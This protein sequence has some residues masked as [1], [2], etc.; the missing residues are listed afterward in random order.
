MLESVRAE[1]HNR[2]KGDAVRLEIESTATTEMVE[3]LRTNFELDSWQVFRTDG[4]VNLSRLMN[5]YSATKIAALKYPAVL[6]GEA[7]QALGQGCGFVCRSLRLQD[8]MLHHP[9][10][11]YRTVE[12]FVQLGA[13]DPNVIS[14]KQTLYRT[15]QDSP[16]F[17]ALIDAAQNKDM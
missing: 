16:I 6:C 1:L 15:S 11:S 3:R 12:D 13:H 10:D 9:F 5:L 4:P 2:R 8:V 7:V 14:M 17:R